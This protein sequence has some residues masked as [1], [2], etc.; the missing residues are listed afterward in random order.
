MG[1]LSNKFEGRALPI[2]MF[3]VFLDAIGIGVLVPLFPQLFYKVFLPAGYS[4]HTAY[5]ALGWL[6]GTYA[7]MQFISTPILGQ[8]SDRF[9]RK[10]VLG[11]SLF[12][13][14]L[15]YALLAYGIMAK[16]IPLLFIARAIAG[17]GGGN[18]SVARA[19]VADVSSDEHRT[20][21]FGLI[22]AVFW[23]TF[24]S[25]ARQL[26]WHAHSRLVWYSN[27]I[28]DYCYH[29]ASQ[30]CASYCPLA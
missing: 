5:V 29:W 7:L 8:L 23:R 26:A 30:H 21:N 28:M 20:R 12:T 13:T 4:M 15:G 9:G 16:N 22:G 27:A 18:V 17:A 10:R 24:L 14:A 11:L 25:S 19:I 3:T 2:V 1:S 6:T